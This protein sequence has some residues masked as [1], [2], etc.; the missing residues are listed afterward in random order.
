M[1]RGTSLIRKHAQVMG[2]PGLGS[3][4]TI[5]FGSGDRNVW[6]VSSQVAAH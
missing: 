3:D 5:Y 2:N 6:A 4:G 1:Y